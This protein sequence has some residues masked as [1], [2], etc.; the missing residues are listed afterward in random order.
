MSLVLVNNQLTD[1]LNE[2]DKLKYYQEQCLHT[3][4]R[5]INIYRGTSLFQLDLLSTKRKPYFMSENAS[6]TADLAEKAKT[7][8]LTKEDI[9]AEELLFVETTSIETLQYYIRMASIR[10][11]RQ[12]RMNKVGNSR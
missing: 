7:G 8:K 10:R 11:I 4:V 9:S 12:K 2:D 3:V 1:H 5:F 6:A